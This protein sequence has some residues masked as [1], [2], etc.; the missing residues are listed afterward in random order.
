MS[1]Y[2]WDF[3]EEDEVTTSGNRTSHVYTRNLADPIT[4]RHTVTVTARTADGRTASA[5][6]EIVVQFNSAAP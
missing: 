5:R 3:G 2:K 4:E 1:S 6:E